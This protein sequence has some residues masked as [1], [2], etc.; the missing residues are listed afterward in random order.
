MLIN[1]TLSRRTKTKGMR[2]SGLKS[3]YSDGNGRRPNDNRDL[4]KLV[5]KG[6]KEFVNKKR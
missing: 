6:V 3:F 2:N 5:I 4:I 1:V